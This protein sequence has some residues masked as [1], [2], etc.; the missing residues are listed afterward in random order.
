VGGFE[1]TV[2]QEINKGGAQ[3]CRAVSNQVWVFAP[4]G[5]VEIVT[6]AVIGEGQPVE[7]QL[8]QQHSSESGKGKQTSAQREPTLD[9]TG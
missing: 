3:E 4:P 2:S 1:L 8:G 6:P 9:Q 7:I 5:Q